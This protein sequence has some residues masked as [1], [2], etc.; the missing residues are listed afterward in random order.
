MYVSY[1]RLVKGNFH[2]IHIKNCQF[3]HF[4]AYIQVF[5]FARK[6][7]NEAA[8]PLTQWRYT[9]SKNID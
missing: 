1:I 6:L 4:V 5:F 2:S 7:I 3:M 9:L 8:E